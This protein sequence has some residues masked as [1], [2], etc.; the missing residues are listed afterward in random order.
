MFTTEAR[1]VI[2]VRV[3]VEDSW[4]SVDGAT[5]LPFEFSGSCQYNLGDKGLTD[6]KAEVVRLKMTEP[7][8]SVRSVK[9]SRV[10]VGAHIY[11]GTPPIEPERGIL[12]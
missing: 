6:L 7:D 4:E 1:D 10:S 12:E 2:E 9:G 5:S 11:G 8:G 3:E